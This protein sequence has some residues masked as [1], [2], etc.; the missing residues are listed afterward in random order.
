MRGGSSDIAALQRAAG[1]RVVRSLL[2]RRAAGGGRRLARTPA[3][4]QF[5]L[6]HEGQVESTQRF[7]GGVPQDPEADVDEFV[8]WNFLV[9]SDVVRRG[10]KAGLDRAA[11]RWAGELTADPLLR[12]RIIGYASVTGGV[13]LNEELARRRAEAVRDHLVG[14]GVAEEQI[15]LDSSG[16]RLPMDE[17]DSPESLARNRRVELSKFVATTVKASTS[18]LTPDLGVFVP[19]MNIDLADVDALRGGN[20][21]LREDD[22]TVT[23]ELAPTTVQARVQSTATAPGVEIGMVQFVTDDLRRATYREPAEPP[24]DADRRMPERGRADWGH[25]LD[26]FAPCRDVNLARQAFSGDPALSVAP[27]S[28]AGSEIFFV[29]RPEARFPLD[30]QVPGVGPGKFSEADW[31]MDFTV[32]VFARKADL[33]V[34]LRFGTWDLRAHVLFQGSPGNRLVDA[35]LERDAQTPLTGFGAP[36]GL[37]LERA[38]SMPTCTLRERM[39]DQLCKPTITPLAGIT[40]QTN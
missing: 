34:P 30:I 12:L 29:S 6:T 21:K 22:D 18:E 8:L 27:P 14:L 17:G 16:S 24:V 1:N 9:G 31:N 15:V 40:G 35:S 37:D 7:L 32:V 11:R 20:L 25:C 5:A 2:R 36:P 39:I 33:V 4:Q 3:E 26:A 23:L 19:L 28:P 13:A 38:M 10:H